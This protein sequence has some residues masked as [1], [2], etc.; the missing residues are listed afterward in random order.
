MRIDTCGTSCPQPVLMT[1]KELDKNSNTNEI[2][3]LT[4]NNTSKTNVKKFLLSKGFN[5]EIIEDNDIFVIRGI[6]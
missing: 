4:D 1:K 6:K 2:E 3:V 5:I